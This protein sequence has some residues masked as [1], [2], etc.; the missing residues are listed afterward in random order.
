MN[1]EVKISLT[2]E[3]YEYFSRM[4]IVSVEECVTR[5]LVNSYKLH[6]KPG[7]LY[8]EDFLFNN[9]DFNP[10]KRVSANKVYRLYLEE[11]ERF[12]CEPITRNTL[13]K[14]LRNT[15]GLRLNESTGNRLWI[16]GLEE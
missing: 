14:E 11:C 12:K 2:E 1:R 13:Y 9:F 16:Y 6:L 15:S 8:L 5:V 10:S 7:H 3:Q 4:G